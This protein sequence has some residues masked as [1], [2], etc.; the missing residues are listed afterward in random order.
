[1]EIVN[2]TE[3]LFLWYVILVGHISFCHTALWRQV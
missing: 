1:M 3:F 2:K